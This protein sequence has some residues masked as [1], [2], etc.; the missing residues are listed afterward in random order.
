MTS[1]DRRKVHF[2]GSRFGTR[3]ACGTMILP[4]RAEEERQPLWTSDDAQV[5]CTRCATIRHNR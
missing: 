1:T 4:E 3:A 5:T 2:M